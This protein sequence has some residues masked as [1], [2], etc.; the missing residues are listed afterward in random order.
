[1]NKK[2]IL[3]IAYDNIFGDPRVERMYRYLL[4]KNII[5][6]TA[7][8]LPEI[9]KN[10]TVLD[11][12]KNFSLKKILKKNIFEFFLFIIKII[13]GDLKSFCYPCYNSF[14]KINLKKYDYIFIFDLKILYSVAN[15]IK[16]KI[17]YGMLENITQ[18]SSIKSFFGI[19]YI[20]E[21]LLN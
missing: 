18:N 13:I 7:S 1:M 10:H 21:L 5:L 6:H 15:R 20:I 3:L 14:D 12:K 2:K 11:F 17:L 8:S 19:P 4:K 9:K 16:K